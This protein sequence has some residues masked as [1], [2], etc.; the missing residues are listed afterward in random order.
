MHRQ[1]HALVV[2]RPLSTPPMRLPRPPARIRPVMSLR[3]IACGAARQ[4]SRR[5]SASRRA[6]APLAGAAAAARAAQLRIAVV[7]V[8]PDEADGRCDLRVAAAAAQQRAQVVAPVR[9][10]AQE[11]LALGGQ[12]GA[13][14]VAAEG[15]RDA[16]DHA[17]LAAA[18]AVA[19]ALGGL[20]AA[21]G[22]DRL[23]RELGAM[24]A[25]TSRRGQHLVHAPAV[26][27]AD[28]HVLD[29]AQHDAA[30][31]EVARHR[32]DL[33]VVRAAL[34]DHV[35]LDRPEP[36]ALRL[37]D[38]A[39]HVGDREIDVVHAPEDRVVQR[40]QADRDALQAGVLQRLRLA[41]E[42]RAVGRQRQVQRRAVGRAQR[43]QHRDQRL[44]V[45]AQQR[46]AAGEAD[47]AHAV[48]DEQAR[49]ARDLLEA[50]QR[51]VRQ[52]G[53][54]LVE[55]FLGHAVAAAEVAAVGDRDAQVAQRAAEP[56]GTAARRCGGLRRDAR[57]GSRVAV[58]GE[59]DDSFGHG[60]HCPWIGDPLRSCG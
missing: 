55:H 59:R 54:V 11:Q 4:L 35:D 10:Q 50:Q 9:E 13:V 47:L 52:E 41:R 40:V 6:A 16:G 1:R 58:V 21:V 34:D 15:L 36:D 39:Q 18:V 25:T 45:L 28:V 33:V 29:E 22:L 24:R 60:R 23:E 27:R 8:L 49:R 53:V 32:H 38:A 19:P 20:A 42:Q 3:S 5:C 51:A 31:A 12:P 37:V 44:E 30:A 17:D 2:C 48:R 46:L 7:A 26:A 43:G 56:V 57:H 14:A